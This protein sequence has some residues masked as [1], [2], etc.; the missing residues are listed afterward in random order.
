MGVVGTISYVLFLPVYSASTNLV[1]RSTAEV[2]FGY[3]MLKHGILWMLGFAIVF[4]VH[5]IPTHYFKGLSLI[6]MPIVLLLLAYTLTVETTIGG[7]TAN[8]WIPIPFI[9]VKFQ[10]STLASVVLMI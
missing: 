5:K 6:A 3:L 9:G 7:T 1:F 4:A 2:S 10:T 8:R